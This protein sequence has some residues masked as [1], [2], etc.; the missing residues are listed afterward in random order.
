VLARVRNFEA[1]EDVSRDSIVIFNAT[2][3]VTVGSFWNTNDFN[4]ESDPDPDDDSRFTK[5]F[6]SPNEQHV[7]FFTGIVDE[8]S[9]REEFGR[10][11]IQ[12]KVIKYGFI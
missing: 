12:T 7:W 6:F 4:V 11:T 2:S 10:Y 5:A 3:G 8:S 9:K 1:D